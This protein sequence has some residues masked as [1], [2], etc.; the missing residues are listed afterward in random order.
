MGE[1]G[2]PNIAFTPSFISGFHKI[3]YIQTPMSGTWKVIIT[4]INLPADGVALLAEIS[5]N[6]TLKMGIM[7]NSIQYLINEPVLLMM[8]LL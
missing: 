3:Y 6:N 1:L 2:K 4:G 7:T 5:M 8:S